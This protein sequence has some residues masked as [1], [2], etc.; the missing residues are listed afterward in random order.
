MSETVLK[1][2]NIFDVS[3]K[4][5]LVTGS[6]T[7]LGEGYAHVFAESGCK[8]ICADVKLEAAQKTA[9]EIIAMGGEATALFVDV[10]KTE[11]I[12]QM[13]AQAIAKYGRIDILVNN[14]GVEDIQNFTD[15]TE[16]LYDKIHAVNMKGVFFVAQAVAKEMIKTGGGKIIN[17]GSLGSYIGLAKSSV[18]CS[19]KGGVIQFSKTLSIELA[20][21]NIQVNCVAPGYFITPMTEPFFNNPEHRAWIEGR[22]PL[23]RWGTVADLAGPMLFLASSASD[24]ITG[25]TIIVDGGWLA[26]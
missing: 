11:T 17:I 25:D 16:E 23:G 3:G 13:C 6:G 5:A 24:Y 14:A 18:Y 1:G 19:T 4:V 26:S 2:K 21:Y 22:I 15:Y 12:A 9:D 10:T 7:G 20:P 8:V